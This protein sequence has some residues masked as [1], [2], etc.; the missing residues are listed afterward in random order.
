M[1]ENCMCF[2]DCPK[3]KHPLHLAIAHGLGGYVEDFLS[4]IYK[5]YGPGSRECD[6][7]FHFDIDASRCNSPWQVP[8]SS[9]M[10]LLEYTFQH[11]GPYSYND[12]PQTRIVA[13]LLDRYPRADEAEI[14]FALQY[15]SAEIVK[16]LLRHW[17]DG[18]MVPKSGTLRSDRELEEEASCSNL[19]EYCLKSL[20]LGPMWYI[21]RRKPRGNAFL[22]LIGHGLVLWI[23]GIMQR[24]YDWE[25]RVLWFV[26]LALLKVDGWSY[27]GSRTGSDSVAATI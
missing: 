25:M 23:S 15:T 10:S 24:L 12:F 20:K 16:L 18:K 19:S 11:A 5:I 1:R 9:R 4:M 27:R 3:P 8:G 26:R 22:W 17:P 6:D 2:K 14:S 13:L 21:A 7:V